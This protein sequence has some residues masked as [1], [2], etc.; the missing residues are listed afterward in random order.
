MKIDEQEVPTPVLAHWK[1]ALDDASPAALKTLASVHPSLQSGFRPGKVPPAQLR[2]RVKAMLDTSGGL[3]E[4]LRHLLVQQGLQ[5][6]L[7]CVLS[8]AAIEA[9]AASWADAVG[10]SAFSGGMV[11]GDRPAVPRLDW[12]DLV[13]CRLGPCLRMVMSL[14]HASS[15]LSVSPQTTQFGA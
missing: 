15:V 11:M 7:V 8:E 10:R 12:S 9:H 13:R 4:A 1:Q 5:R 2:A 6:Q 14:T 3:P